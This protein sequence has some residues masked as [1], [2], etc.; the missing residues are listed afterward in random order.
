[1]T[2]SD[3]DVETLQPGV[4]RLPLPLP[5]DALKAVNVYVLEDGEGLTLIDSGWHGEHSHLALSSGL[6]QLGFG[7]GDVDRVL[8]THLHGDHV[9]QAATLR[10]RAGARIWLGEHERSALEVALRGNAAQDADRD[11]HVKRLGAARLLAELHAMPPIAPYQWELPDRW[12]SDADEVVVGGTVLSSLATPG[13][14]RGHVSFADADR[15]LLFA[16]DH[17]LPH[18]TPSIGFENAP[19]RTAL[20]DFLGSL[21][22]VRDLDIDLVLPAHGPV[23]TD[24]PGRVDELAAHHDRRLH[25]TLGIAVAGART[26]YDVAEQLPWTRRGR[27]FT[28]L[29]VF[30]RM[31]AAWETAAHLELLVARGELARLDGEV[32]EY[33]SVP[34]PLEPA[35][36]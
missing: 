10:E 27:A 3:P 16:G 25:D 29:G 6:A 15:K 34:S 13:H 4:H 2:W 33:V 36:A 12:L 24:L 26:A 14:T 31:L 32:V 8:V 9:G 30:D 28:S 35:W 21:A 11:A 22:R 20:A 7:I 18:I 1:M 23:F 19:Q 5:Q 17:V